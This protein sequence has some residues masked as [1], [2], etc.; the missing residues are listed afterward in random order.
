[1]PRPG[2]SF[3]SSPPGPITVGARPSGSAAGPPAPG[4]PGAGAAEAHAA[5][6][7]RATSLTTTTSPTISTRCGWTRAWSTPA[8]T[9]ATTATP[10][11]CAGAEAR[12]HLP[13]AHAQAR[14]AL[15][16]HRLRLGRA[17]LARGA[18]L[19]RQA[20]GITLSRE[21][22]CA[23][24]RAHPRSGPGDR[25]EVRLQDYRDVPGDGLSTRSPPSACSST[26]A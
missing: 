13:Q 19:R 11:S 9:S 4:S 10:S 23:R 14:R 5:R 24:Q 6:R 12:P 1:M 22:A 21:P 2:T 17:G 20:T 3:T 26:S 15:P 8:P 25:C 18:S 16:R 7:Q